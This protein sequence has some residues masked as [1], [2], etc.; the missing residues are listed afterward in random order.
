MRHTIWLK[1]LKS[2][3]KLRH[4]ISKSGK[5]INTVLTLHDHNLAITA[6]K[7]KLKK[8]INFEFADIFSLEPLDQNFRPLRSNQKI[9][10]KIILSED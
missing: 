4:F 7:D 9:W 1:L 5:Y 10:K 6:E 2:G 8:A 3:F